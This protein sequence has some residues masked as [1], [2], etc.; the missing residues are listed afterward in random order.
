M[1]PEKMP[2]SSITL[3]RPVVL[4]LDG[5]FADI[6]KRHAQGGDMY[7]ML[8]EAYVLGASHAQLGQQTIEVT[9]EN[10]DGH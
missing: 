8:R 1:R 5:F 3:P 7:A 9:Q 2:L 4:W 10:R 6:L